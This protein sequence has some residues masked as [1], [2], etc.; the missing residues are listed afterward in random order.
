MI[1]VKKNNWNKK[2]GGGDQTGYVIRLDLDDQNKLIRIREEVS[3]ITS[4]S[5]E[6]KDSGP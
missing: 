2:R 4:L 6:S 3:P 1:Y 5:A